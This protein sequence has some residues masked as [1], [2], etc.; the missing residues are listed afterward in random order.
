MAG[1]KNRS[2]SGEGN[3]PLVP[4]NGNRRFVCVLIQLRWERPINN[5]QCPVVIREPSKFVDRV[6]RVGEIHE[7]IDLDELDFAQVRSGIRV[8]HFQNAAGGV[9]LQL[10]GGCVPQPHIA[11][12]HFDDEAGGG[13]EVESDETD[14]AEVDEFGRAA[15]LRAGSAQHTTVGEDLEVLQRAAGRAVFLQRGAGVDEG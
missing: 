1:F 14:L 3:I 7:I 5:L 10:P 4:V 13:A 12:A 11:H 15:N 8:G 9:C 6:V 2:R